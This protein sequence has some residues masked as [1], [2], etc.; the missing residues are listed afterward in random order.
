MAEVTIA[1]AR[2]QVEYWEGRS[3]QLSLTDTLLQERSLTANTTA[4]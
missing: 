4:Q 2:P 3:S 1:T